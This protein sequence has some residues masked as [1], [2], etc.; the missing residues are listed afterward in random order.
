VADLQD[1]NEKSILGNLNHHSEFPD[2]KPV[3]G[4]PSR[5]PKRAEGV[6]LECSDP[7]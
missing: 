5:T 7:L 6:R 2:S 3:V 4:D 1:E